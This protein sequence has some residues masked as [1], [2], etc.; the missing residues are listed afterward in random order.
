MPYLCILYN[1]RYRTRCAA[2]NYSLVISSKSHLSMC[3]IRKYEVHWTTKGIQDR[4]ITF[5][6]FIVLFG[7]SGSPNK[8]LLNDNKSNTKKVYRSYLPTWITI[9]IRKISD[10]M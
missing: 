3:F 5:R 9:K 8:K 2:G 4:G 7:K 10:G 6:K 1:N